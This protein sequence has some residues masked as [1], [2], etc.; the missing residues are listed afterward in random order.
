MQCNAQC[1]TKN[2]QIH[3]FRA[4]TDPKMFGSFYKYIRRRFIRT[5]TMCVRRPIV[6]L[7]NIYCIASAAGLAFFVCCKH[8]RLIVSKLGF[9]E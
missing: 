7:K 2:A 5:N 4:L 3:I 1:Y 8:T 6:E 9:S